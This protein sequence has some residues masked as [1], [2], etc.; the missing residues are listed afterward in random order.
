[1]Q[2]R[3][4]GR[5]LWLMVLAI[6]PALAFAGQAYAQEGTLPGQPPQFQ[7]PPGQGPPGGPGGGPPGCQPGGPGG[8][9]GGAP[10]GPPPGAPPPGA[11][12]SENAPPPGGEP[13]APNGPGGQP[14]GP[15][16]QPG[17]PG[18]GFKSGFLNRVW[19]FQGEVDGFDDGVLSMTMEKI[20]NLPKRFKDQDD[21]LIDQDTFVLVGNSV[22]VYDADKKRV[23]GDDVA[24]ALGKAEKV[25]VHGKMLKPDKWRKDADDTKTPTIRAKKVYITG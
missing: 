25:R 17:G 10:N 24:G 11:S 8:Q 22:R 20:L 18:C 9:P 16:G 4:L 1:M 7:P 19:K 5:H 6:V 2:P 14:G 12:S 3:L 21:E 23:D 15:G 13:G